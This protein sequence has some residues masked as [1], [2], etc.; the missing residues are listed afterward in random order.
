MPLSKNDVYASEICVFRDCHV[1]SESF[2]KACVSVVLVSYVPNVKKTDS[3]N[4]RT[5]FWYTDAL[6]VLIHVQID[7]C[8]HYPVYVWPYAHVVLAF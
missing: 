8:L 5:F 7:L 6:N 2:P 1:M 4:A 3:M